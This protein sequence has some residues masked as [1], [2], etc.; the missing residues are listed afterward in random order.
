MH[1]FQDA[2]FLSM[3]IC[4]V[5]FSHMICK[6]KRIT[7]SYMKGHTGMKWVKCA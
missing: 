3:S 6:A 5:Q 2:I 1:N 4:V 7:G